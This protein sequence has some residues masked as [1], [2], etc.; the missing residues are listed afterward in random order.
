MLQSSYRLAF[1]VGEM[2]EQASLYLGVVMNNLIGK[3]LGRYH[4]IEQLGEGGMASVFK[5]YDTS[6]ERFV[7]VKVIRIDKGQDEAFLHRFQREAKALARLEHPYILKVLDYGEQE[8][9]PFLVMPFIP[10]GTLKEKM[11]MPIPASRAAA[12]LAPIA[13]A[14]EYAHRQNIIHRDVKPANILIGPSGAPLLSDF[15]IAKMLGQEEG[16]TQLTSTGVGIGTPDYMAPEQWMGQADPR[17]DVYSLGVVFYEMVTG[18]R[19]YTADT[20]AA[21]LLKHVQ[22][23]LPQPRA[24]APGLPVA[25]EQALYKALAK[26]PE[27]RYQ[28]AG[29][30]AAALEMLTATT[31]QPAPV[32][33]A[34]ATVLE[35]EIPP[36]ARGPARLPVG[37][38]PAAPETASAAL[39]S[40]PRRRL[41]GA[42]IGAGAAGAA[43][44]ACLAL[45]GIIYLLRPY[46]PGL[47]SLATATTTAND[48]SLGDFLTPAAGGQVGFS[49]AVAGAV[50]T[51]TFTAGVEVRLT[52]AVQQPTDALPPL[53]E[54]EGLPA[55]IPIIPD[56][57]GDLITTRNESA[58]MYTFS[59]DQGTEAVIRFYTERMVSEGWE[60]INT[61]EMEGQSATMLAYAKGETRTVIINIF[62]EQNTWISIMLPKVQP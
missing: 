13:R 3:S 36:E 59:T 32:T 61:T 28:E 15:G 52:P 56:N 44:V 43:L 4:I 24:F 1:I 26:K 6:L 25:A 37:E 51:A 34:A 40:Q 7:A 21:V 18:R 2:R 30:F 35:V 29:A 60:L 46:I 5:A 22:D 14:L 11:G 10:G 45:A 19:P 8:G 41:S 54:I 17:T 16:A 31:A 12:V 48:S 53:T 57:N 62:F 23:P 50:P 42:V 39:K 47:R 9:L 33:T 58:D 49:T 27:D 38:S 55:D 20:P